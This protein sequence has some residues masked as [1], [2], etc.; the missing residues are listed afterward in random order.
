MAK[1]A[2]QIQTISKCAL[3]FHDFIRISS[4]PLAVYLHNADK[5]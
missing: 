1:Y 2:D 4:N 3:V 5:K